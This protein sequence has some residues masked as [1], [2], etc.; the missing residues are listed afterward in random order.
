MAVKLGINGFGRIGRQ[1]LRALKTRDAGQD[2]DIVKIN[3]LTDTHTLAHLLRHDSI[4]GAYPGEVE[5]DGDAIV[6]GGERILITAQ[7]DPAQLGWGDEGIDVVLESTGHFT[8]RAGALRHIVDA[9]AKKVII[10][11]PAKGADAMFV[12]GVNDGDYDPANH[13]ILSNASCTTNCLAPM[14]K[15]LLDAFGI[16]HGLMTT[17]HSYTNDQRILDFPHSDLRRARAAALNMIP[18]KTGAAEAIGLVIPALRDKLHGYAMRVP[19]P[20]VSA[21]DLVVRTEKSVTKE[22]VK[23]AFKA[24]S[25][26]GTYRGILLATEEPLV[27]SDYIGNTYSS[28]VDLPMTYVVGGRLVKTLAWYD[29]EYGYSCRTADLIALVASKL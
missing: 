1:V 29:N 23:E 5:E 21:T 18:T 14:A 17:I 27:S 10:S 4:H 3:D 11:A 12:L 7:R 22:A 20:D 19:T 8:D 28:I 16:E 25:D 24:A 2:I 6:V 9:G 26:S 13:H 15:V